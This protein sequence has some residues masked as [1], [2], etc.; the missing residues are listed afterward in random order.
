MVYFGA[1]S[2]LGKSFPFLVDRLGMVRPYHGR[3]VQCLRP[4]EKLVVST[5]KLTKCAK[6][7][8]PMWAK[9]HVVG[10][11]F[12]TGSPPC[13]P[14]KYRCFIAHTMHQI[15]QSTFNFDITSPNAPV[16]SH[17]TQHAKTSNVTNA[18]ACRPNEGRAFFGKSSDNVLAAQLSFASRFGYRTRNY[19][20]KYGYNGWN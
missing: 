13:I 19:D 5:Y 4:H 1:I 14:H 7:T 12:V 18:K 10:R 9:T 3:N 8:S 2:N 20:F 16:P 11:N 6:K 15:R 17:P